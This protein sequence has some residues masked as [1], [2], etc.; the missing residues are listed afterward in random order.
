MNKYEFLLK[1]YNQG[2]CINCPW[3]GE[4]R[5]DICLVEAHQTNNR[6]PITPYNGI[7][8]FKTE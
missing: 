2:R 6:Q 5:C 3:K 7:T 8:P 1:K 4:E